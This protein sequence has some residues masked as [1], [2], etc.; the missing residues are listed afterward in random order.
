MAAYAYT[1][2]SQPI[3]SDAIYDEWCR[4][5]HRLWYR[6]KHV[7]KELIGLGETQCV[8]MLNEVQYPSIVK[9][10]VSRLLPGKQGHDRT[11]RIAAR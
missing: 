8:V 7:H 2:L 10:A 3:V 4:R 6:V 9:G 5:L 11:S 1:Q